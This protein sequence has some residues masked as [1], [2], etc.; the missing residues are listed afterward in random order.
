M[1]DSMALSE[2]EIA[3]ISYEVHFQSDFNLIICVE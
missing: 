3:L 1:F 2:T